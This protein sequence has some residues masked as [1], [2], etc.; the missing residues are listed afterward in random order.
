MWVDLRTGG[1]TLTTLTSRNNY[2][3]PP[4]NEANAGVTRDATYGM[5]NNGGFAPWSHWIRFDDLGWTRGDG[6]TLSMIIRT[7]GGGWMFGIGSDATNPTSG[8]QYYEMEV[9]VYMSSATAMSG[10]Y[11]NNGTPGSGWFGAGSATLTSGAVYK[12]I[13]ENDAASGANN[14]RAYLLPSADPSDWDDTSTL[15]AQWTVSNPGTQTNLFPV[16]VMQSS[17]ANQILG[18]KV[19]IP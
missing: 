11:G 1:T 5:S 4:Q 10:F 17:T 16:A 13:F 14:V 6:S 18:I 2:A 8:A 12:F 15:A 7:T 19:E 3:T 9:Q